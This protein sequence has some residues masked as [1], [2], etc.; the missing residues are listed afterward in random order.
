M[1]SRPAH[2]RARGGVG[3]RFAGVAGAGVIGG[4]FAVARIESRKVDVE[5]DLGEGADEECRLLARFE[6]G[7]VIGARFLLTIRWRGAHDRL[8]RDRLVRR[9]VGLL[10]VVELHQH[11]D[12]PAFVR[13]QALGGE[14]DAKRQGGREIDRLAAGAGSDAARPVARRA[15]DHFGKRAHRS[16]HGVAIAELDRLGLVGPDKRERT[17]LD[18]LLLCIDDRERSG[19]QHLANVDRLQ[20]RIAKRLRRLHFNVVNRRERLI[21][22]QPAVVDRHVVGTGRQRRRAKGDAVDARGRLD[23]PTRGAHLDR[24]AVYPFRQPH[25]A[26]EPAVAH[27]LD[28]QVSRA[29]A[30]RDAR[31]A[32]EARFMQGEF[33]VDLRVGEGAQREG[34]IGRCHDR[35]RA[36]DER[37]VATAVAHSDSAARRG[38]WRERAAHAD[39]TKRRTA[40][41]DHATGGDIDQ[42]P[43]HEHDVAQELARV[44]PLAGQRRD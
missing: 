40:F 7:D 15:H 27:E 42:R 28:D 29:D 13:R 8:V 36:I 11:A 37:S 12:A 35:S 39:T 6:E 3:G 16:D 41:I 33:T 21:T 25:R 44:E 38:R 2:R 20:A 18:R 10:A 22:E 24:V 4:G 23:R 1:S 19:P 17:A 14:G 5:A 32:A 9:V 31:I 26:L 34:A 43:R 30:E